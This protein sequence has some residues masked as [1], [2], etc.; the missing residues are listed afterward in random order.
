MDVNRSNRDKRFSTSPLINDSKR[1]FAK[2][3]E[4]RTIKDDA[5]PAQGTFKLLGLPD[6]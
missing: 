2:T 3:I 4:R 1:A 6:K 5:S